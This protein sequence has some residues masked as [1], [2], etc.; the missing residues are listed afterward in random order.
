MFDHFKKEALMEEDDIYLKTDLYLIV[1]K[2]FNNFIE[3]FDSEYV[4]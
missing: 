4:K 3:E 2:L 1:I